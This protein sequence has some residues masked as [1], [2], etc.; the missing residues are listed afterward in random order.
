MEIV[1]ILEDIEGYTSYT[2]AGMAGCSAPDSLSSP[3]AR[4]LD[5]VRDSVVELIKRGEITLDDF[6]D[7]GQLHQVADSG[8]SDYTHTLWCEFVDLCAYQEEPEFDDTWGTDLN[9]AAATALYQICSRLT[10]ALAAEWREGWECPTCGAEVD[11]G[12]DDVD[13]CGNPAGVLVG[14]VRERQEDQAANGP[15][16]IGEPLPIRTPGAA[17]AAIGEP[18]SDVL[19]G[20]VDVP[21]VHDPILSLI[22]RAQ[23]TDMGIR[24]AWRA[25]LADAAV[26]RFRWRVWTGAAVLAVVS[27]AVILGK[28]GVW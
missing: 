7:N 1:T 12:C 27:V 22:E 9:Q 15:E 28:G 4:M 5:S 8:P 16:S 2:L 17:M 6:D 14:M 11:S 24:V 26:S 18:V 3:G 20:P 21:P 13:G 10:F 19:T 23:A 25:R